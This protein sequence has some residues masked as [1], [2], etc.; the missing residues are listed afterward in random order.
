[1]SNVPEIRSIDVVQLALQGAQ[2]C[3]LLTRI[4]SYDSFLFSS[5]GIGTE[6]FRGIFCFIFIDYIFVV[7]IWTS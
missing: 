3:A 5:L 7:R 2:V 1:M 4:D 6:E